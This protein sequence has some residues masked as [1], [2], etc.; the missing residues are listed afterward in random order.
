MQEKI[1]LGGKITAKKEY[2]KFQHLAAMSFECRLAYS[3][4]DNI[5]VFLPKEKVEELKSDIEMVKKIAEVVGQAEF[6]EETTELT[7]LSMIVGSDAKGYTLGKLR[8]KLIKGEEKA[9]VE[10]K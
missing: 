8:K 10:Q 4:F 3:I 6:L 1:L 5:E 9:E 7:K 2:K